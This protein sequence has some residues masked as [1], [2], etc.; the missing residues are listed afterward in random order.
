MV[1]INKQFKWRPIYYFITI[2]LILA[3]YVSIFTKKKGNYGSINSFSSSYVDI[4]LPVDIEKYSK[5]VVLYAEYGDKHPLNSG[6]VKF[7]ATAVKIPDGQNKLEFI[8]EYVSNKI[9]NNYYEPIKVMQSEIVYR[10]AYIEL[11]MYNDV[12]YW[13]N[14]IQLLIRENVIHNY[15]NINSVVFENMEQI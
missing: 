1:K 2:I 13:I 7:K 8:V 12:S 14:E 11:N 15:P 3:L 6:D 4:I 10:T 5:K 9:W